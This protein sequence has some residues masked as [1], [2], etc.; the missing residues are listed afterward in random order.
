MRQANDTNRGHSQQ[1]THRKIWPSR[2][3]IDREAVPTTKYVDVYNPTMTAE[4]W[5]SS[6]L[7]QINAVDF[8][9]EAGPT[10]KLSRTEFFRDDPKILVAFLFH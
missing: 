5:K 6:K 2:I 1:S 4:L 9:L 10:A 7:Y 3:F 8:S